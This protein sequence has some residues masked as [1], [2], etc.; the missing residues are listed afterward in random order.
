VGA[1]TGLVGAGGGF[2]FVPTFALFGGMPMRRAVGTSL[3]VI[4]LNS[5]AAL[6]GHLGHA[7]IRLELAGAITAAAVTGAWCGALLARRAPELQ[8]RRAFG[9]FILLV[10][11]WMLARSP[12]VHR[13]VGA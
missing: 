7:A 8:L 12:W 4:S 9:I 6:L 2:L 10:A 5:L 11:L 13:L 3:V 1:V